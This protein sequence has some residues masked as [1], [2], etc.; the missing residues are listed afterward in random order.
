M[1]E[2]DKYRNKIVEIEASKV[3]PRAFD[4]A[5]AKKAR[6]TYNKVMES[7]KEEIIMVTSAKGLGVLAENIALLKG[8]AAKGVE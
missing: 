8:W 4:I 6:D 3:A 7:A 2:F 1:A 5:D